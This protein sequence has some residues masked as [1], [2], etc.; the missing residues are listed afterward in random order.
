MRACRTLA[1]VF[2]LAATSCAELPWDWVRADGQPVDRNQLQ[3]AETICRSDVQKAAQGRA[4][5]TIDFI[6]G[7]NRQDQ[8]IYSSCMAEYGF[9]AQ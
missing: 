6:T 4:V 2:C 3:V 8:T 1:I 9:V 5:G 7:P